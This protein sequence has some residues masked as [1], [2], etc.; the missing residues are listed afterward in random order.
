VERLKQKTAL[1]FLP[2]MFIITGIV[3]YGLSCS[4][5]NKKDRLRIASI[6]LLLSES[7]PLITQQADVLCLQ[8]IKSSRVFSNIVHQLDYE[9][10]QLAIAPEGGSHLGVLSK[11][12]IINYTFHQPRFTIKGQELSVRRGFQEL[13]IQTDSGAFSL[14]HVHLKS[15]AFHASMQS[16]MRRNELR[17]LK[18]LIIKKTP[19]TTLLVCGIFNENS[20]SKTLD[21]FLSDTQLKDTRPAD[22]LGAAWTHHDSKADSYERYAYSLMNQELSQKLRAAEIIHEP[23]FRILLSQYDLN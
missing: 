12:P 18:N 15:T 11:A 23:G 2:V 20:S 3:F 10:A 16:E 5:S 22:P 9:Y 8:G 7:I 6:D 14:I 19:V 13:E 1:G 17:L 4:S 21:K